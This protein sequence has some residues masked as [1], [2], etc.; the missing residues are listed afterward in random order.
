M[1]Q[2][3]RQTLRLLGALGAGAL[4]PAHAATPQAGG[5]ARPRVVVIGGGYGGATA[6]KYLRMWSNGGVDVSLVEREV[7]FVSCPLSNLVLGDYRTLDELS[8]SYD[9]LA[10]RWGVR[11]VHGEVSAIDVDKRQVRLADGSHLPYDRV[12]VAPGVDLLPERIDGY[13]GHE[14]LL[15]HAWKAGPQTTLL[16][17]QIAAM[18]DNGVFA[19]FVPQAP[20]R[21]PPG[22]YERACVVAHW[23]KQ[24]KPRA[25]VLVYDANPEVVSKKALFMQAFAE[26]YA[27]VLEYVPNS[28]LLAVDAKT[29]SAQLEFDEVRADVLNVIPPQRAGKLVDSFGPQ[30]INGQWVEV[31][32][33]TMGARGVPGVHVIGDA[34][35]AADAM[36]KSGHMANQHAKHAAAAVLA[37]L[38]G[39]APNADALVMN[40][41]YSFVSDR[42]VIHVASVHRYEAAKST[43]VPVEGAGGVSAAAST[44]EAD[45][46]NGWA[47]TI[48]A[49][50]MA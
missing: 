44:Q 25:K 35:R 6:A 21:C 31:D 34:I 28:T 42:E 47:R 17:D 30:L 24:H 14:E 11:V 18:P 36:P 8:V 3:R 33:L 27:G 10:S 37:L 4:L 15:P 13:A 43:F 2:N 46:A 29:R 9:T 45:Y 50:M 32:F 41:C 19:M 12:I 48:W 49:D 22:P 26:R 40:T 5:T 23:L 20:Y 39:R 16:R 38:A 1:N 7:R